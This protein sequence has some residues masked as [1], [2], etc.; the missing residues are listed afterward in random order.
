M[1]EPKQNRR[2]EFMPVTTQEQQFRSTKCPDC[3]VIV[4]IEII[5]GEFTEFF[6]N[7]PAYCDSCAD[8]K[9][10]AI[11]DAEEKLKIQKLKNKLY[12][13]GNLPRESADLTFAKSDPKIESMNPD[14]WALARTEL[15]KNFWVCGKSGVGKTWMSYAII[16]RTLDSGYP[17][18]ALS[19]PALNNL[20]F[21]YTNDRVKVVRRLGLASVLLIDDIDKAVWT[22]QGVALLWEILDDRQRKNKRVIV[23]ANIKPDMFVSHSL[24]RAENSSHADSIMERFK[25]IQGIK[26]IGESQR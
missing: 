12:H 17:A 8:K 14:A 4:E 9:E 21:S 20:G 13:F 25:P 11:Y 22:A 15:K 24:E 18:M 19:G 2:K 23:T 5:T 1:P 7:L 3:S 26:M 6:M 16:N 10:K